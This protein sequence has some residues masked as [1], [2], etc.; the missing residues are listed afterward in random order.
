MEQES[1]EEEIQRN[2]IEFYAKLD[3]SVK[4]AYT[5]AES[6][7]I[8]D[9]LLSA[10]GSESYV[11]ELAS[12]IQSL[13]DGSLTDS[14]L[15]A[16]VEKQLQ[17]KPRTFLFLMYLFRHIRFTNVEL[18]HFMFEQDK[19]DELE[20]FRSLLNSSAMFRTRVQNMLGRPPWKKW[21]SISSK[22]DRLH[23]VLESDP[24]KDQVALYLFKKVSDMFCSNG[25]I[26]EAF[27]LE[28]VRSDEQVRRRIAEFIVERENLAHVVDSGMVLPLFYR[29]VSMRNVE[30]VKAKRG[31]IGPARIEQALKQKG[32]SRK[33]FDGLTNIH[34]VAEDLRTRRH[35]ERLIYTTEKKWDSDAFGRPKV[36]DFLL[37]S[38]S[39]LHYVIETNYFTTSMSKIGEVVDNFED[40]DT[41]CRDE[42]FDFLY[43]TD[44]I[45]WFSLYGKV[46]KL[47]KKD[48]KERATRKRRI[49]F[50]MNIR[51][52]EEWLP[53]VVRSLC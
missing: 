17:R 31:Q 46:K 52:F 5:A 26:S 24:E 27:W 40:L 38:G 11:E 39:R 35:T 49:P 16:K 22:K 25:R 43:I 8:P 33:N 36:F 32:F 30:Q 9:S 4:P 1:V 10:A 15:V 21:F 3:M 37:C 42:D 7:E 29:N 41:A 34:E 28:R 19:M 13:G 2:L 45:G 48:V 50:F 23:A 12:D 53:E 6:R 20:Y 14:E 44:G 47:I 51:M 18:L